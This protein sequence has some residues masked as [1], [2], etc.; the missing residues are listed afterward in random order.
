M[1]AKAVNENP[2]SVLVS[3]EVMPDSANPSA[4]FYKNGASSN[5]KNNINFTS[6]PP[7]SNPTGS[8]VY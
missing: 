6:P 7:I 8:M 4:P 1:A 2:T 5:N 3:N